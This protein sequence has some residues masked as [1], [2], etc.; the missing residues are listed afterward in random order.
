MFTGMY[1]CSARERDREVFGSSWT[2]MFNMFCLTSSLFWT[3]FTPPKNV[4]NH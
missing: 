4:K 3:I 2:A 1:N